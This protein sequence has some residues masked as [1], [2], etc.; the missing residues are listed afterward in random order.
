MRLEAALGMHIDELIL[1]AEIHVGD[2]SSIFLVDGDKKLALSSQNNQEYG[3]G[4]AEPKP[5]AYAPQN[6]D[7]KETL[8]S[9]LFKK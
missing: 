9:K 6:N 5:Q 7:K 1:T 4:T 2:Y 8:W 3:N